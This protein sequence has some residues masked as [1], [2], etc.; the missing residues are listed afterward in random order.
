M[1][2]KTRKCAC[3]GSIT[4]NDD[5]PTRLQ[6]AVAEHRR[7]PMHQAWSSSIDYARGPLQRPTLEAAAE[8]IARA[9][10][11]VGVATFDAPAGDPDP[12]PIITE[13]ELRLMD[14]NR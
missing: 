14:G 2:T 8:A 3:G 6:I 5:A 9:Q 11:L 12:D 4:A 1:P 7:S 13:S 10:L